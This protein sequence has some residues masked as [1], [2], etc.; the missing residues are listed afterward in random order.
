VDISYDWRGEFDNEEVNRLHAE[1]F[2]TEVFG[3]DGWNWWAL[4]SAHSLDWVTARDG[5]ALVRGF[6][7]DSCGFRPTNAGLIELQQ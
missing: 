2:G 7:L 4:T 5:A 1:A 6:Y 3:E